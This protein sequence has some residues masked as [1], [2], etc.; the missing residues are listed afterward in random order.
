M[1]AEVADFFALSRCA[2]IYMVSAVSSFA[3]TAAVVGNVPLW[4]MLPENGTLLHKFCANVRE[5]PAAEGERPPAEAGS[6]SFGRG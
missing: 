2:E 4:S 5:L 6:V 1:P 3:A